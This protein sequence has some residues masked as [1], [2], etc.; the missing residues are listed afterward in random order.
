MRQRIIYRV[1]FKYLTSFM[2]ESY[3]TSLSSFPKSKQSIQTAQYDPHIK[4]LR[5]NFIFFFSKFY[6]IFYVPKTMI[7]YISKIINSKLYSEKK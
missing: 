1:E 2:S 7:L 5:S 6:T 4:M 3:L